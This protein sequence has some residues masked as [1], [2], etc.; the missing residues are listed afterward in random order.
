MT[1][2]DESLILRLADAVAE[3]VTPMVPLNIA[4]WSA[5]QIAA[6]CSVTRRH[7]LEAMAPLPSFPRCI[8]LPG[9]GPGNRGTRR[10][11]ASDVIE[12]AESRQEKKH[13]A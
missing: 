2:N 10:W 5:D 7:V 12:W 8:S 9:T 11:K 3:R 6:Y 13:A 4:L 1:Q